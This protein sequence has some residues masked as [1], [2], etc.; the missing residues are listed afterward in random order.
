MIQ[1]DGIKLRSEYFKWMY[2]LVCTDKH[3]NNLSY[4]KLLRYLDNV[5]FVPMIDMD[6]NRRHD[7]IDFRYQFGYENGISDADIHTY[8]DVRECSV[9]EM[10]IALAYRV[11]SQIMDNYIYGNRTGQW[12]W[13]MIVSL[14]L[15][16]MDDKRFDPL[17]VQRVV[18][19]FLSRK[20]EPNGKGSLFTLEN[21]RRDLRDVDIWCQFMWY[22]SENRKGEIYGKN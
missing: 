6:D 12:F 16:S 21:P 1:K 8:L 19:N 15:G 2:H 13:T 3:Y 14:G 17:Y 5:A 7:G 18:D 22:L 10:M 11:E 4:D 9:L 20:F